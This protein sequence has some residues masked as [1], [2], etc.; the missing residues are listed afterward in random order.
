MRWTCGGTAFGADLTFQ[1]SAAIPS[2]PTISGVMRLGDGR[3]RLQFTGLADANYTVIVSTN[4][5]DWADL[6]PAVETSPGQF[7]F[8]DTAAPNHPTRFYQLRSP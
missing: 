2:R 8:T 6:G 5:I 3:F 4:L 7:D 1:T